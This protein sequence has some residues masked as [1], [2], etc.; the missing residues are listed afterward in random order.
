[1]ITLLIPTVW[2]FIW[3]LIWM[4]MSLVIAYVLV[5][6]PKY[7]L[8]QIDALNI[9]PFICVKCMTFWVNIIPNTILAYVTNDLRFFIYGLA[10][11]LALVYAIIYSD[12]H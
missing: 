3:L 6:N 11:A 9:Y 2:Q 7:N 12:K 8:P 4:L 5:Y 1:M 10:T